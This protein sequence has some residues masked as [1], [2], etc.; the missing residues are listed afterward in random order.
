MDAAQLIS[1][2]QDTA[3]VPTQEQAAMAIHASL[4]T[5]AERV[6]ANEAADLA[7]QLSA[8]FREDLAG[9]GTGER[10]GVEEFY[11]RVARQE[12]SD[13]TEARR[14]ARAVMAALKGAVNGEEFD[15]VADQLPREYDD[16][17][18]TKP[19]QH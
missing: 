5:L 15:E 17:L 4:R 18:T 13:V 9:S 3:R 16:L 14:H 8:P 11:Q 10:F 2:V 12:G 19:V 7:A 6:D 1:A